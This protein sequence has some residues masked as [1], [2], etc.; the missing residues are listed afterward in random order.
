MSEKEIVRIV[1]LVPVS[2]RKVFKAAIARKGINMSE[3]IRGKMDELI[4]EYESNNVLA[5]NLQ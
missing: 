3:W 2:K 5:N 4:E 1:A